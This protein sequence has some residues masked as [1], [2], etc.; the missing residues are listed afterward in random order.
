MKPVLIIT[1]SRPESCMAILDT[2]YEQGC[3]KVYV[4][5][6]FG[7]TDALIIKQLIF[8]SL[9]AAYSS[10]FDVFK[11]WRRSENLGVAV[12][13]ITA[14]D[15]FF[16]N[17]DC[18]VILEDDLVISKD[19]MGFISKGLETLSNNKEIFS[20]SGSNF[21]PHLRTTC[22]LSTYFVGWGWGTWRDRW[23]MARFSYN[24]EIVHPNF[25]LSKYV[26]F[27]SIGAYRCQVGMIDTWDIE[28]TKYLRD[29]QLVTVIAPINFISNVGFDEYAS[30]TT[31]KKFPMG[32][33]IDE[34]DCEL[35]TF[36]NL[37]LDLDFDK[38]LEKKV[39]KIDFRHKF[40]SVKSKAVST[41]KPSRHF[42]LEHRLNRV[43][44]P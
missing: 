36:T 19:F 3:K 17:E 23:E 7:K 44:L 6:D 10:K 33:P 32:N 38:L 43:L 39:F 4:A 15:W 26:N 27:W 31:I 1:Y 29:N 21:F 35:I 25:S 20:I 42:S 11:V 13:V 34:L 24:R 5:I 30:N 41:F 16:K 2:L 37:N 14:I 28:L 8:N 9:E 12:S 40:L 18:G 22:F